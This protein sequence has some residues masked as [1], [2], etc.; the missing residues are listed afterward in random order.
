MRCDDYIRHG[1]KSCQYVIVYDVIR[2]IVEEYVGFLFVNVQAGRTDLTLLYA[3]YE[4][5]RIDKS[6][7]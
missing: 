7:P 5:L 2:I 1:D 6:T 3:F 4:G